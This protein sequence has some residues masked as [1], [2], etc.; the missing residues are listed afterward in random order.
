MYTQI[1]NSALSTGYEHIPEWTEESK[2]KLTEALQHIKARYRALDE[3]VEIAQKEGMYEESKTTSFSTPQEKHRQHT[4]T[5]ILAKLEEGRAN[6]SLWL[7]QSGVDIEALVEGG[8]DANS[9]LFCAG[10]IPLDKQ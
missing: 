6:R 1:T 3:L 10:T 8:F 9:G 7:E 5:Y 2:Q 4:D